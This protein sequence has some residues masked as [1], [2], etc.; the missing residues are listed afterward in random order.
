MVVAV[1]A[2]T[3]VAIV[4]GRG[5]L[6]EEGERDVEGSGED[7]EG[8]FIFD[9]MGTLKERIEI[10]AEAIVDTDVHDEARAISRLASDVGPGWGDE[11]GNISERDYG[12]AGHE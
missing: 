3:V 1:I 5:A 7:G 9:T 4:A 11:D 10:I 2:M 8:D 12:G 6:G